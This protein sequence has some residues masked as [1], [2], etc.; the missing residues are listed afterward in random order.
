MRDIKGYEG[1]YA[2]TSCGKVWSYRGNKF[3]TPTVTSKGYH[4]VSLCKDGNR[5]V[6]RVHRLVAEAYIDNPM[7][8]PQI[9]HKDEIKAHNWIGNLE[10]CTNKYNSTYSMGYKVKCIET[11]STFDS[12]SECARSM[13]LDISSIC[14]HLTGRRYTHVGGYHF[15]VV[16]DPDMQFDKFADLLSNLLNTEA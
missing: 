16:V 11:W 9:N 1:L 13:N 6:C 2:V 7:N 15:E 3:L 4:R 12:V 14:Q 8:Y 10:W 5:K